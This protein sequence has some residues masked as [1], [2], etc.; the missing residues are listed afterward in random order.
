MDWESLPYAREAHK[1]EE[2]LLPIHVVLGACEDD[3]GQVLSDGWW[4]SDLSMTHISF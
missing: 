1:R 4:N 3:Q 2:H